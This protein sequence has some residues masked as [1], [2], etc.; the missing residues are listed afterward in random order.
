MKIGEI[1]LHAE[2]HEIVWL[3]TYCPSIQ[4]NWKI[5]AYFF[6]LAPIRISQMHKSIHLCIFNAKLNSFWL[7][8]DVRIAQK[9]ALKQTIHKQIMKKRKKSF[10]FLF[11]KSRFYGF[12]SRE[13]NVFHFTSRNKHVKFPRIWHIM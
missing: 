12:S 7:P 10:Y 2:A 1:G 6:H 8:S 13:M 11:F 4:K 3:L 9:W 5:I